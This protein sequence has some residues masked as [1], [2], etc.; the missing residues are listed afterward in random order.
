[1][2]SG[3]GVTAYPNLVDWSVAARPLP[4]EMQS[5]DLHLVKP[6]PKGVLVAAV[7]GLGHGPLAA[8]AATLAV[9][10]LEAHSSEDI[11]S[12]VK[13]CHDRLRGTRGVAM[14]LGSIRADDDSLVWLGVGNVEGLLL[15]AHPGDR[16]AREYVLLRGGVVGD[17]LPSLRASVVSLR[18]DDTLI[19]ATDGIGHGFAEGLDP[20]DSPGEIAERILA[21]HGKATDDALVLVARYL[22]RGK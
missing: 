14:T 15:R 11:V 5:G 4:G 3:D 16:L 17:H 1:M 13:R 9:A 21:T 19:L 20:S 7:D 12:L 8:E 2:T 22:G 18:P 6:L 10:V